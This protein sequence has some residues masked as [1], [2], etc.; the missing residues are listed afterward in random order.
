MNRF[1]LR[2]FVKNVLLYERILIEVIVNEK[3]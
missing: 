3:K 2:E 1:T